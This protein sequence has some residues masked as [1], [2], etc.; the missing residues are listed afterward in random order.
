MAVGGALVTRDSRPCANCGGPLVTCDGA[1]VAPQRRH[2]S[3]ACRQAFYE[4]R[5]GRSRSDERAAETVSTWS[6]ERLAAARTLLNLYTYD[7]L[8]RKHTRALSALVVA[9]RL[10]PLV[11]AL[12]VTGEQML[13]FDWPHRPLWRLYSLQGG[14]SEGNL[15]RAVRLMETVI[16][17]TSAPHPDGPLTALL[18]SLPVEGRYLAVLMLAEHLY[19][20]HWRAR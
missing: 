20:Q 17:R 11:P 8:T 9:C 19:G 2:C 7:R 10:A 5:C 12:K 18:A 16:G 14:P 4:K 3:Q 15:Q 6:P 1:P 13:A